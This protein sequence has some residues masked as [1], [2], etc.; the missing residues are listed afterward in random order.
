MCGGPGFPGPNQPPSYRLSTLRSAS[1]TWGQITTRCQRA[2]RVV[3]GVRLRRTHDDGAAGTVNRNSVT[4]TNLGYRHCESLVLQS[5]ARRRRE[6]FQRAGREPGLADL[7]ERAAHECFPR[8]HGAIG[9]INGPTPKGSRHSVETGRT[10]APYR[11]FVWGNATTLR[12]GMR[13]TPI[14]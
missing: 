5:Q 9:A 12:G 3:T 1:N 10:K 2:A 6:C 7:V 14:G 8:F 13:L 11:R 4:A